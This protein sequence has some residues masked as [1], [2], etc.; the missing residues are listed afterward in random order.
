MLIVSVTV[1]V[2]SIMANIVSQVSLQSISYFFFYEILLETHLVLDL[3]CGA[4]VLKKHVKTEGI[5][6]ATH[7]LS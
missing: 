2:V 3:G 7:S 6:L 1:T 5:G 4:N